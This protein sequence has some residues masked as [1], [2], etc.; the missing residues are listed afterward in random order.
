MGNLKLLSDLP[1][2]ATFDFRHEIR[3]GVSPHFVEKLTL[4][5]KVGEIC[6]VVIIKNPSDGYDNRSFFLDSATWVTAVE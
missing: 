1:I 6:K 4:L 2:G 5:E 3:G